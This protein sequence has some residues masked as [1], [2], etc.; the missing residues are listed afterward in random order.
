MFCQLGQMDN[1]SADKT[2]KCKQINS[3]ADKTYWIKLWITGS[4]S[5]DKWKEE[6]IWCGNKGQQR[7]GLAVSR[8]RKVA[9]MWEK[10]WWR[11]WGHNC[12]SLY[13]VRLNLL[14]SH[15]A[16]MSTLASSA[17]S[18][19]KSCFIKEHEHI[20]RSSFPCTVTIT[21]RGVIIVLLI[22][23]PLLYC[24][25]YLTRGHCFFLFLPNNLSPAPKYCS[26]CFC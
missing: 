4:G 1:T 8:N 6:L 21:T 5:T 24:L 13:E 7:G 23:S 2:A 16:S 9:N 22:H 10:Q 20:L 12:Y 17:S 15:L 19:Y 11:T 14:I 18:S 26:P 25:L 3:R